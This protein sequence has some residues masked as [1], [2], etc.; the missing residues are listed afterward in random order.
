MSRVISVDN[1]IKTFLESRRRYTGEP[2]N[3]VLRRLI[4]LGPN[5]VESLTRVQDAALAA[6]RPDQAQTVT[7]IASTAG[8]GVS[9][10]GKALNDLEREGL[11][12]RHRVPGDA[13]RRWHYEWLLA[14]RPH[15]APEPV[16]S[17]GAASWEMS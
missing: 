16:A 12:I 13:T 1:N 2:L 7:Q 14:N 15:S 3:T 4:G 5:P 6:L 8:I 11:A 17:P 10:A 9:T